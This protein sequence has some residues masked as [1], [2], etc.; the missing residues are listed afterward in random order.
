MKPSP[1]DHESN[2]KKLGSIP[3]WFNTMGTDKFSLYSNCAN[4]FKRPF[5][6]KYFIIHTDRNT[7]EGE[8]IEPSTYQVNNHR[9]L[10]SSMYQLLS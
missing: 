10:A 8:V 6:S 5:L 3:C 1:G 2:F 7:S 4:F 9:Q